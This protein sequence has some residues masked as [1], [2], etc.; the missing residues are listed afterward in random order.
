[1]CV[2]SKTD[3]NK[4]I[5]KNTKLEVKLRLINFK[6]DKFIIEKYLSVSEVNLL[7]NPSLTNHTV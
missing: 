3:Q 7:L 4:K 1:V 6:R 2:H 5:S